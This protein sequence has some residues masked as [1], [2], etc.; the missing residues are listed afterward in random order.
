MS[1]LFRNA[2]IDALPQAVKSR[3][4]DV[5]GLNSKTHKEF[6]DHVS[7]AVEQHRKNEQKLKIQEKVL[8]RKLTPL[9]L[10]ELTKK[11]K[12][13]IQAPIKKEESEQ[14]TLMSPVNTPPAT[15]QPSP[16]A[17]VPPNAHHIP[18]PII[19]DINSTEPM[20]IKYRRNTDYD[21][22]GDEEINQNYEL[23]DT[24]QINEWYRW[25]AYTARETG[26]ENCLLCS[27]SPLNKVI[28]IP[29]PYDYQKS[30][31]FGRNF[32]HLT[33]FTRPYCLAKCL[34]FLGNP[35]LTD[36]FFRPLWGSWCQYSDVSQN[37]KIEKR[38]VEIPKWYSID[39]KQEYECFHK[40][41]GTQDVGKFKGKCAVSWYI[42]NRGA[43]SSGVKKVTN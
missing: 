32:C 15:I 43:N 39:Y 19:N 29:N 35:K 6:C 17:A 9:Q 30:D 31:E 1:T 23:W 38:K 40:P 5:V 37:M 8:Q 22:Q 41:K 4:E 20:I 16:P 12:K 10:A 33:D 26:K 21:M 14:I 18:V 2:V 24:A 34:G 3:L 27:K 13:M 25:A 28:A 42:D 11:N 36:Y 7:H